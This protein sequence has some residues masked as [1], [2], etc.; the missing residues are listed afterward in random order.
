MALHL[1]KL[2]VGADSIEDLQTWIDWRIATFGEQ[3]HTTRQMPKRGDEVL[4]GGSLFWVIK[5]SIQC[6][7]PVLALRAVTDAD[8]IG[9]CEIVLEPRVVRVQPR[10]RGPFQGW[11]YLEAKDAAPDLG[12]GSTAGVPPQLAAE[13]AELGL[14]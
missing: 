1:I 4:D 10:P 2:A 7:Q 14:L 12:Q 8:G 6:R 3:I 5:G 9:R 13:L 11:R